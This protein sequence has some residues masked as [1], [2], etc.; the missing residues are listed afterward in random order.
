VQPLAQHKHRQDP[1]WCTRLSIG[2][3]H[4]TESGEVKRDE[5]VL[6]EVDIATG[7]CE[8][9]EES[10]DVDVCGWVDEGTG[11]AVN[12]GVVAFAGEVEEDLL[13]VGFPVDFG[14]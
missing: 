10:V 5:D 3:E 9:V 11:V 2:R 13:V 8:V 14:V 4:K 6:G 7:V 1:W 12:L